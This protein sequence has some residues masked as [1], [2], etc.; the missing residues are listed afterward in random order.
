MAAVG[1]RLQK[2]LGFYAPAIHFATARIVET[3]SSRELQ[4]G[5]REEWT[6]R[7]VAGD[8]FRSRNRQLLHHKPSPSTDPWSIVVNQLRYF[9][10][11][12][13][14]FA[15]ANA[16]NEIVREPPIRCKTRG[17]ID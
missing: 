17:Q 11:R 2:L 3:R 16:K 12:V 4:G 15:M 6:H 9:P 1:K 5:R 10:D 8:A 7:M 13:L 14:S